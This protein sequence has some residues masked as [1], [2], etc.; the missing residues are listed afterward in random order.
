MKELSFNRL[1][2]LTST[3]FCLLGTASGLVAIHLTLVDRYVEQSFFVL[4]GVFW[5]AAA[6]LI[7]QKQ[8][9]LSLNSG[10]CSSLLG[11]LLLGLVLHSSAV[12]HSE[13]LL[14]ISPFLS[15]L[16]LGLL[17]SGFKGLKQYWRELTILFFLGVPK[18]ICEP[19]DISYL[20]AKFAAVVLW[21]TGFDVSLQGANLVMPNGAVNVTA[22]CS[23]FN[24]VFYLLGLAVLALLMYPL[25]GKKRLIVPV[26]AIALAFISNGFRVVL[27]TL[28]ANTSNQ[29]AFDYWHSGTGSPIFSLISVM[30]FGFFY[31]FL[32]RQ[33]TVM[34]ENSLEAPE[35]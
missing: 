20:T 10:L 33:E 17:A 7:W 12:N 2:S 6:S 29:S 25:S 32:L 9:R 22:G 23:G 30:L 8:E 18:V 24:N 19:L 21:Y 1:R 11:L 27:V 5:A 3:Q 4:S 34:E 31:L 14:N 28:L 35:P 26:V 13:N 15:G 16:G